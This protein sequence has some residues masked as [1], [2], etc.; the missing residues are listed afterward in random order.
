MAR[1]KIA[2]N[3]RHG[4]L[5]D[6]SSARFGTGGSRM[7]VQAARADSHLEALTRGR[8]MAGV[9]QI[10]VHRG[11]WKVGRSRLGW[12]DVRHVGG[13]NGAGTGGSE[14]PI[15]AQGRV[16]R[17]R[18]NLSVQDGMGSN[19]VKARRVRTRASADGSVPV[20]PTREMVPGS[21]KNGSP[22]SRK[23]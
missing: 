8:S 21:A 4:R 19:P 12:G 22:A 10:D 9:A 1:W 3:A 5:E 6:S 7:R 2:A 18:I 16:F 23:I 15:G 13:R 17:W 20:R 11:G 14:G